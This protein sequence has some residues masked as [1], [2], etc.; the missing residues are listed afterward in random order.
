MRL[1]GFFGAL[2]LLLGA[3]GAALSHAI[4]LSSSP[5]ADETVKG[6]DLPIEIRFNSQIDVARS[7]VK[8]FKIDGPSTSLRL[9]DVG[10][11]DRLKTLAPGLEPGAYR[12]HWQTLSPDGHIT[13]GDIPFVVTR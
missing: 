1:P 8:L 3:S 4:V 12:L 10:S 7:H 9:Q 6:G 5:R 2:V 11:G 13:Q